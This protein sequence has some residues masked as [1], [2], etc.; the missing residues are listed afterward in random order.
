MRKLKPIERLA[1]DIK[2]GDLVR[3]VL[4]DK[5]EY[6]GYFLGFPAPHKKQENSRVFFF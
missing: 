6:S 5:E 2:V 3:V 4:K 1:K